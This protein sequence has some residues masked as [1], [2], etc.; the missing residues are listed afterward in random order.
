VAEY[1]RGTGGWIDETPASPEGS[2]SQAGD[3]DQIGSESGLK[4]ENFKLKTYTW[5]RDLS[6]SL[7]GAGG[8]GGLLAISTV[9]PPEATENWNLKTE[10]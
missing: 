9:H 3:V 8:V 1:S 10:N 4:T 2:K 7:Q 5:G 6:G